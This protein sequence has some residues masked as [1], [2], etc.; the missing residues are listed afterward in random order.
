MDLEMRRRREVQDKARRD[1]Q[2]RIKEAHGDDAAALALATALAKR[3]GD[4]KKNFLA[5]KKV[6]DE[7]DRDTLAAIK[8]AYEQLFPAE[9]IAV[10]KEKRASQ[11][12]KRDAAAKPEPVEEEPGSA[13]VSGA[14][15]GAKGKLL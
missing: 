1:A 7:Q 10:L 13:A 2:Q 14:A 5:R 8:A 4:V 12:E 15:S 11:M 9:F 6:K 3:G